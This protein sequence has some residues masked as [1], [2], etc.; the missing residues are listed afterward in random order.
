MHE[1]HQITTAQK[2]FPDRLVLQPPTISRT[3]LVQALL[4]C[5]SFDEQTNLLFR[6]MS[7]TSSDL[8]ARAVFV[9]NLTTCM[10]RSWPDID[11]VVHGSH[12][13]GLIC[14]TSDL[15]LL[16]VPGDIRMLPQPLG[17]DS[18]YAKQAHHLRV[19]RSFM[20]SADPLA[21]LQ[22]NL[23]QSRFNLLHI[24]VVPMLGIPADIC[25]PIQPIELLQRVSSL[26]DRLN[27]VYAPRIPVI[28]LII[29]HLARLAGLI[30]SGPSQYFTSFKLYALLLHYLQV[31]GFAPALNHLMAE[32]ELPPPLS[33]S[34]PLSR[35]QE[36]SWP[37]QSVWPDSTAALLTDFFCYLVGLKPTLVTLC[38]ASGRLL[39]RQAAQ[40]NRF[41]DVPNP[42]KLGW[43]ILHGIGRSEWSSFLSWIQRLQPFL[44]RAEHLAHGEVSIEG[45]SSVAGIHSNKLAMAHLVRSKMES[46]IWG[47]PAMESIQL[48]SNCIKEHENKLI[49]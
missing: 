13:N 36:I 16:M 32:E 35:R 19:L 44:N 22:S 14:R 43:N 24:S 34:C 40:N 1:L 20:R 28:M 29:K 48:R 5:S 12:A 42:F 45:A 31:N 21:R 8:L 41:L 38:L 46:P 23:L 27:T 2:E 49:F 3:L 15:D 7:V 4:T 39:P 9:Q 11:F 10:R 6:S 18:G 30:Q 33:S 47:I 17:G 26:Y 25:F 37:E